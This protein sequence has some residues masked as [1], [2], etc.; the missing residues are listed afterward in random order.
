VLVQ[1]ALHDLQEAQHADELSLT[2]TTGDAC[3][4]AKVN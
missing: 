2:S 1:E 4:S 3:V